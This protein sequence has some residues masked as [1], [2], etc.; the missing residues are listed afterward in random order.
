VG[1][2]TQAQFTLFFFI[3]DVVV[4]GNGESSCQ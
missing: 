4:A 2:S 1:C 3:V